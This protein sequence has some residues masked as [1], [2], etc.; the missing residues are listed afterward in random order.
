MRFTHYGGGKS[1]DVK[2][3]RSHPGRS[4]AVLVY[5][6]TE[7]TSAEVARTFQV[8]PETIMRWTTE[9]KIAGHCLLCKDEAVED[10]GLCELHDV[11][12]SIEA[13]R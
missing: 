10:Q 8:R 12:I 7:Q 6:C 13:G 11:R 2:R 1:S 4:M 3:R 9:H 5:L